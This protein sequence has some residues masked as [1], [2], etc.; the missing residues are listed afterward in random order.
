MSESILTK[1]TLRTML[2]TQKTKT[3]SRSFT[4]LITEMVKPHLGKKQ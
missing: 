2:R 4:P 3:L 1:M